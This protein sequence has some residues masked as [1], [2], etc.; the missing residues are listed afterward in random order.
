VKMKTRLAATLAASA[1]MIAPAAASATVINTGGSTGFQLLAQK[2]ANK[3]HQLHHVTVLV[4]GGGSGAGIKGAASGKFDIGDSSR[5]PS[6]SDP[7]GLWFIPITQEPIAVI[8]NNHNPIKNLSQAQIAGIFEGQITRWSQVG[9]RAGGAIRIFS[10]T[11][12]SGTLASFQK[13]YLGGNSVT[14]A[15]SQQPSNGLVRSNVSNSKNAVGFVTFAYLVGATKVHGLRVNNVAPTLRNVITGHFK[16]WTYQY[17]VTKGAPTGAVAA[18]INWAR[19][20]RVAAAIIRGFAIPAP[21]AA[22]RF[23]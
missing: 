12:T 6:A 13:V 15:A 5:D 23:T 2:L 10:R 1:V 9:W 11:S 18:Y 7:K 8:V 3:Y 20:N 4:S 22:I 14:S 19:Y 16:Y 17:F 21:G